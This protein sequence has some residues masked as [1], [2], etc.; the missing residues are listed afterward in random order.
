MKNLELLKS[1]LEK[2]GVPPRPGLVFDRQKHRWVRPEEHVSELKY[3]FKEKMDPF[4]KK[5]EEDLQVAYEK[6]NQNVW[7]GEDF[8]KWSAEEK[9]KLN[10]MSNR[11]RIKVLNEADIDVKTIE[12]A[13]KYLSSLPR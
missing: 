10:E 1:W 3:S 2:E 13:N 8:D 4:H 11:M 9:E 6:L 5:H 12:E 7:S